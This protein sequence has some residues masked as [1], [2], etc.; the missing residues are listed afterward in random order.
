MS[1]SGI[2]PGNLHDPTF[3]VNS[4]DW[5]AQQNGNQF[6]PQL[7]GDYRE[8]QNSILAGNGLYDDSF[9]SEAFTMP[10]FNSPLTLDV[11]PVLPKKDL[12]T[13]IDDRLNAEEEVVPGE[14]VGQMLTCNHMWE[15][16]QAC[17]SVQSGD[18]DMD[19]LCSQ[20]QQKAKCSGDGPVIDE[21]D[22]KSVIKS[23]FPND[24][25]V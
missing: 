12:V 18:I 21:K 1:E 17:P 14:A 6:D 7:F 25:Y 5:F 19:S 16:L 9:F 23:M 10:D 20:L 8:P 13:E 22:F 3:D 11:S 4:I 15:K 2:T 24:K